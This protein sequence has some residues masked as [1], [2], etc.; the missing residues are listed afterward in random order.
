MVLM[1][2]RGFTREDFGLHHPGGAL[3]MSLQS[4]REWMGDNAATPASVSMDAS[5]SDVVSAVSAG[6]KGAVAVLHADGSLAGMITDG[7]IRRAFSSDFAALRAEDIMSRTP[8]T[9]DPDARMSDVVDLLSANK[10]ANLFVVENDR[11]VAII[12]IAELMQAGYVS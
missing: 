2:R 4:V 11:P 12:H 8:I 5:F 7:D 6:R 1:D 9:V 10:I 3:G